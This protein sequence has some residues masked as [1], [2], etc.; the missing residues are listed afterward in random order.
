MRI[1]IV[2]F[3]IKLICVWYQKICNIISEV[4]E[5]SSTELHFCMNFH[6]Q[7]CMNFYLQNFIV[8]QVSKFDCN[9]RVLHNKMVV[10][11]LVKKCKPFFRCVHT[12]DCADPPYSFLNITSRILSIVSNIISHSCALF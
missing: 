3:I 12:I 7:S 11:S 10:S 1:F 2:H 5:F 9:S 8:L 4:H 6:L